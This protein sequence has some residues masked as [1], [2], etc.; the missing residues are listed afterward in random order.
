VLRVAHQVQ[1]GPEVW[2]RRVDEGEKER[3]KR[4]ITTMAFMI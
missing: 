2:G 1:H 4:K 3:E